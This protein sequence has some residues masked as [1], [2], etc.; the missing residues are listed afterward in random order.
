MTLGLTIRSA[1]GNVSLNI[2]RKSRFNVSTIEADEDL[3]GPPGAEP[4]L[5]G[6]KFR[7]VKDENDAVVE[8]NLVGVQKIYDLVI[9]A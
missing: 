4:T 2:L 9:L 6:K 5:I 3:E 7:Q 8:I 1:K